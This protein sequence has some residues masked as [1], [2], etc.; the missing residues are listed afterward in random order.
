M[1]AEDLTKFKGELKTALQEWGE[2]KIDE[3]FPGKAAAKQF[4]KNGLHNILN[5]Y[6]AQMNQ[7]LDQFF[8]DPM[9]SILHII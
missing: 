2:T 9:G 6:D 1:K 4:M 5:R 8:L 3:L 7:R